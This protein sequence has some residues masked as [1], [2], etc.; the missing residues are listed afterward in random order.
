[1][2]KPNQSK[3][4]T[5]SKKWLGSIGFQESLKWQENLKK[6][7][8]E[9]SI[10][11]GKNYFL[12]FE[13]SSPIISLGLRADRTHILKDDLELKSAGLSIVK[14]RRGGEATLHN[15]GQLVIYPVIQLKSVGLRVKD[16]IISL[17]NITQ[18]FLRELGVETKKGKDFAGLYTKEGKIA[19]FG[20]H[21][22]KGV[23]QSGLSLNIDNDLS[24]FQSIKSCGE[25]DRPHDKLSNYRG[26]SL[27]KKQLF[28]HWSHLAEKELY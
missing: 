9:N 26:I 2:Q 15:P 1:M 6:S 20:I 10:Q 25:L 16:F 27:D 12:G 5:F 24:L 3:F 7:V 17:Q 8:T 19:F 23:S 4:F 28:L 13:P 22:S 21:I 14:V 18:L 11:T